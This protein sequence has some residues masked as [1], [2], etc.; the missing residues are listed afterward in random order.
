M[1]IIPLPFEVRSQV[2]EAF[3][4]S[5]A[6]RIVAEPEL[7]PLVEWFR[8]ALREVAGLNLDPDPTKGAA[9]SLVLAEDLAAFDGLP[10]TGGVRADDGDPHS[11]RYVLSISTSGVEIMAAT[12]EGVFRGL[13][14]LVQLAATAEVGSDGSPLLEPAEI[15][16]A[17]RFAWRGLSFDVVRTFFSAAEVKRVID[18]IALYKFNVLHL[19]LTD[20]EG[21]RI[22]IDA[23]P[24]L[25]EVGGQTAR[26]GRPGGFYSKDAFREIV[27]YAA[28]RFVTIVPEFEMPGHTAA[29]YRA[30]PELAGDGTNPATTNADRDPHFQVMHPDNPR[31]LGFVADVL[32][33]IAEL[34]PGAWLHLGGDEA[35]GMDADLY[36]RFM[37]GAMPI[38]HGLGKRVVA[39]QEA[40]RAGLVAGDIAQQ[41]IS[42]DIIERA[43]AADPASLDETRRAWVEMLRLAVGDLDRA[44]EQGAWILMSQQSKS[45]LDTTYRE[46]SVDDAQADLQV[47]L[48][49]TGY[50]PS[51][52]A[53]FFSWDPVTI[54]EGLVEDRIAGVEA[55]L[56]CET[57]TSLDDAG[58]LM[59]PRLPG[60]AEKGWSAPVDDENAAWEGYRARLATQTEVWDPLGWPYFR[61]EVVWGEDEEIRK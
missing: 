16:D 25:T 29:I 21:W 45:Y 12:N 4:L 42:P 10:V 50:T 46:R 13:T 11:E 59:L 55:A 44:L 54:R 22:E 31:I 28:E 19:H 2:G 48:G 57:V 32:A 8:T 26:D 24:K 49:L 27:R 58:F 20:A 43:K 14:T 15:R 39:W 5:A 18:L 35:L 60:V 33:E 52:V 6:T 47:R 56:W 7:L 3:G 1:A 36:S 17:P 37:N 41:W 51:T 34:T 40:S 23:W 53:E 30:Y 9:I 38:V 61:S